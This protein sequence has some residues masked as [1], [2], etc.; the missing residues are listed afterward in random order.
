MVGWAGGQCGCCSPLGSQQLFVRSLW[1]VRKS[2]SFFLD[3][4]GNSV[5]SEWVKLKCCSYP[6]PPCPSVIHF[7]ESRILCTVRLSLV[8]SVATL[9][10]CLNF[11]WE[12]SIRSCTSWF[13]WEHY[14]HLKLLWFFKGIISF[15]FTIPKFL[16][17][18]IKKTN[19]ISAIWWG[20]GLCTKC[21]M[22]HLFVWQMS[23]IDS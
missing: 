23:F 2:I 21:V 9:A 10:Y 12:S 5:L 17:L 18:K 19:N 6:P 3:Q 16:C 4:D 14:V 13:N 8:C 11:H 15:F 22:W 20:I 7:W 1:V